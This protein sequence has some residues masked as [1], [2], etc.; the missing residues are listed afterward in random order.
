MMQHSLGYSCILF[1][2]SQITSQE[3]MFA[4]VQM[5]GINKKI[6]AKNNLEQAVTNQG[7]Q[8]LYTVIIKPTWLSTK[9]QMC[10]QVFLI[11]FFFFRFLRHKYIIFLLHLK[12]NFSLYVSQYGT[13]LGLPKMANATVMC[14]PLDQNQMRMEQ[15]WK[16]QDSIRHLTV[17]SQSGPIATHTCYSHMDILGSGW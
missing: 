5:S 9:T 11:L 16:L 1:Y 14:C 2:M 15:V 8:S 17:T 7:I 4:S 6:K 12:Y 13:M 10:L 3:Q